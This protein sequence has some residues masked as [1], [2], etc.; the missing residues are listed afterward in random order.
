M[1]KFKKLIYGGGLLSSG[2]FIKN[3][4]TPRK[5][6]FVL[7]DGQSHRQ[8]VVVGGGIIGLTQ[9]YFLTKDARN[10]V[11]VLEK[12]KAA[13]M[14]TSKQNGC[15][16]ITTHSKPMTNMAIS[17]IYKS[18]TRITGPSVVYANKLVQE[19]PIINMKWAFYWLT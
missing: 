7:E 13:L 12:N 15:G 18:M 14:E 17:S 19:T 2:I 1:S 9:A 5:E 4:V 11:T 16:F 3:R 8:I 10:H 6:P